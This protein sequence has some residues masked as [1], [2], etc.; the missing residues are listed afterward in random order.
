[1]KNLLLVLFT[2]VSM[3][4]FGQTAADY[5]AEAKELA[6]KNI[7]DYQIP[8]KIAAALKL[9]STNV[10]YYS[11]LAQHY[12]NKKQYHE[13]ATLYKKAIV[14]DPT[15]LAYYWPLSKALISYN[16]RGSHK[17]DIGIFEGLAV[18]DTLLK[19]G[20]ASVKIYERII[21]AN[22]VI[23]ADYHLRY[24]NFELPKPD[25]SEK[26]RFK[27]IALKAYNTIVKSANKI[28]ELDASNAD[29]K[30]TLKYL[31]KPVF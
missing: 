10:K 21:I 25:T 6:D 17:T 4:V 16:L 15:N 13:A 24:K 23:L 9:D 30:S 3:S 26:E 29:A 7:K 22:K 8:S 27:N 28:L 19:K 12:L 18:L 2:V 20:T 5:Y 11:L 1:M 14:L 31:E